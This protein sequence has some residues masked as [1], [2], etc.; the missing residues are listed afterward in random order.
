MTVILL[1]I[2]LNLESG[3]NYHL[4]ESTR[5]QSPARAPG[6]TL[7]LARLCVF[8]INSSSS[9]K[10]I[11]TCILSRVLPF[12]PGCFYPSDF[13]LEGCISGML[14]NNLFSYNYCLLNIFLLKACMYMHACAC[15]YS[16]MFLHV[17]APTSVCACVCVHK[18][19]HMCVCVCA[20]VYARG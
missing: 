11:S 19:V 7:P 14:G 9:V 10:I 2:S 6:D 17:C 3:Y 12:W 16:C 20:C 18:C 8:P 5:P 1:K 15:M 4:K 13:I